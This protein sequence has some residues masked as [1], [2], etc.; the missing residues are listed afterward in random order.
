[1]EDIKIV[2][3]G[4]GAAGIACAKLIL[5]YGNKPNNLIVCDTKGTI[6]KGRTEGMNKYK[7]EVAC[8]T[9]R[10][11][12]EQALDGADCFIGVSVAG[13][14]TPELL[15]KMAKDPF[16]FAMANP[17]PEIMPEL[18]KEVR[19]DCIMATGRSDY[20]NQINNVMCFPYIF[21]GALD[22]RASDINEDMKMAAALAIA[23]L[24]RSEVP[25][26][27]R[28]AYDGSE[29]VFGPDYIIPTPFDPRLI[30]TIPPAV[31]KAAV[32]SGVA[33]KPIQ[34]WVEYTYELKA[35]IKMANF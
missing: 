11:T 2:I 31:A 3:N 18:A 26:E 1:M 27:V 10:R 34:D 25:Q 15:K 29:I 6:Y 33:I 12:L 19:P 8:E 14:L 23:E 32:K 7:E 28:V 16:I 24:A 13:A 20:P 5:S 30:Y 21:R 22:V 9:D 4:A 35:R 17:T